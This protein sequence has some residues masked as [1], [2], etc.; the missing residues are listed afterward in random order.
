[1][2][3]RK[4]KA[5][6]GVAIAAALGATQGCARLNQ[7]VSAFFND[8]LK[9]A[10]ETIDLGITTTSEPQFS[11]YFAVLSG[12]PFGYGL[13]DGTFSGIGGGDVGTMKIHYEHWGVGLYGRETVGWG[14]VLFDLEEF[15]AS[16][17]ETMNCQSVGPAGLILPPWDARPAGRPT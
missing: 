5:A 10:L 14:N 15:D 16:K 2:A 3:V 8:R 9:D 17:P 7:G 12:T 1:M 6:L 13:V 11:F 4:C